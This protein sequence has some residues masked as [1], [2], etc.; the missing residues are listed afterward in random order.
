LSLSIHLPRDELYLPSCEDKAVSIFMHNHESISF[1]HRHSKV[2]RS[3]E[4]SKRSQVI[5]SHCH[6]SV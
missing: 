4:T 3:S 5:P 2:F 6:N 1:D